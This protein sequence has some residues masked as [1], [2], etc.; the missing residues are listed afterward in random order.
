MNSAS[1]LETIFTKLKDTKD[2][3]KH[4]HNNTQIVISLLESWLIIFESNTIFDVYENLSNLN[5]EIDRFEKEVTQVH[6]IE[7]TKKAI[8]ILRKITAY[9]SLSVG[10]S[11]IKSLLTDKDLHSLSFIN[12][13]LESDALMEEHSYSEEQIDLNEFIDMLRSLVKEVNDSDM[14]NDDKAI[15]ISFLSDLQKGSKLYNIHGIDALVKSLQENLCKYKLIKESLPSK[16]ENFKEKTDYVIGE[17]V[18]WAEKSKQARKGLKQ[19]KEG[20]FGT[21]ESDSSEKN[22]EEES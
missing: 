21:I 15:F 3:K 9:P 4:N 16:Y 8:I 18:V 19:L 7:P 12:T 10:V 13:L 17:I 6:M 11:T 14:N 2:T 5:D 20:I 1:R 22:N